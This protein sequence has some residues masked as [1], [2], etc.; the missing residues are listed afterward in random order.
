MMKKHHRSVLLVLGLLQA[1]VDA[2]AFLVGKSFGLKREEQ[3]S[4]GGTSS[5]CFLPTTTTTTTSVSALSSVPPVSGMFGGM[6]GDNNDGMDKTK[7]DG[8]ELGRRYENLKVDAFDSLAEYIQMWAMESFHSESETKSHLL[9]TPV[10]ITPSSEVS[11]ALPGEN[12]DILASRSIKI[13]FKKTDSGYKSKKDERQEEDDRSDPE[14]KKKKKGNKQGG[15]EIVVE[16]IAVGNNKDE[17]VRVR[18]VRCEMDEDT[19]IKEMSEETIVQ[20]LK[21]AMDVWKKGHPS[22]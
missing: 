20:E 6:F 16:K 19:M 3:Q 5:L 17:Q 12:E 9:A 2:S 11:S 22:A 10:K 4:S 14:K 13:V 21:K 7:M 8:Y 18:A 15:V 1:K